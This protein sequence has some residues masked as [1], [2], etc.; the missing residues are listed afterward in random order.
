MAQMPGQVALKMTPPEKPSCTGLSVQVISIEF[1]MVTVQQEAV[2][3]EGVD[4]PSR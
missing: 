4:S 1:W 2:N 3:R